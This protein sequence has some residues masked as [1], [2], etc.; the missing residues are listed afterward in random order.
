[1]RGR[2]ARLSRILHPDCHI[3]L[4]GR[5]AGGEET[6]FGRV[7]AQY[8]SKSTSVESIMLVRITKII[9]VICNHTGI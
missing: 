3:D 4:A 9:K 1:M 6:Q 7:A 2:R 8:R 5:A